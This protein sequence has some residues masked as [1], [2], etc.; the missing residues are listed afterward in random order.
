MRIR[1]VGNC[2]ETMQMTAVTCAMCFFGKHGQHQ[3]DT[4]CHTCGRIASFDDLY[5][6]HGSLICTRSFIGRRASVT[7]QWPNP[8]HRVDTTPRSFPTASFAISSL[9]L[10]GDVSV[11]ALPAKYPSC[12]A[13][14]CATATMSTTGFAACSAVVSVGF[15]IP[16]RGNDQGIVVMTIA[17]WQYLCSVPV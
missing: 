16:S 3:Y 9:I 1:K 14:L 11:F 7:A 4:T 2:G 8:Q 17:T 13:Y 6:F 15:R 5:V 10:S 12:H